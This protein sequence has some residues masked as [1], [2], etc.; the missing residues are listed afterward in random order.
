MFSDAVRKRLSILGILVQ[1]Y[2]PGNDAEDQPQEEPKP[3]ISTGVLCPECAH[4]AEQKQAHP[5][6][7][8]IPYIGPKAI[9]LVSKVADFGSKL[10]SR[11]RFISELP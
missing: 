4:Y 5:W 10:L 1:Q 7:S 3:S 8:R 9:H 11:C 2:Q 6:T